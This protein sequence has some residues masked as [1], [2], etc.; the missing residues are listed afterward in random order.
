MEQ[1]GGEDAEGLCKQIL[2]LVVTCEGLK[3]Q[4]AGETQRRRQ[5][6][7]K[8]ARTLGVWASRR[9]DVI[10]FCLLFVM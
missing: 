1:E 3:K 4:L 9:E 8:V 6:E 10:C 7:E 2:S 5:L